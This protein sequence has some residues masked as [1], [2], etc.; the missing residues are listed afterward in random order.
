MRLTRKILIV[1]AT[2]ALVTVIWLW[3]NR[4]EPVDMA[5]YV[6]AD[7]IV[8]IE[9]N[10]LPDILNGIVSTDAYRELAP[11]AGIKSDF[12]KISW[13]SR[14]AALTGIGPSDAVVLSRSQVAVAV[15]GF[16]AAEESSDILKIIPRTALVA[17]TH[18]STW[19]ARAAI[20]KLAGDFARRAYGSPSVERK[21]LDGV[22]FIIWH[23]PVSARRRIVAAVSGSVVVVGNDESAVQAC[24]AVRRGE[25]PSLAANVELQAMRERLDARHS[26]GF[27]FAP[28]GSAARMVEIFAPVFVTQFTDNPQIQS[29]LAVQLPLLTM[30]VLGA[31]GWSARLIDGAIEDRYFLAPSE[32]VAP[33]LS[34]TLIAA[35]SGDSGVSELLPA[36]TYQI[37]RY[38]LRAPAAAWQGFYASLSSQVD[39]AQAHIIERALEALLKPYGIESPRDFLNAAGNEIVTAKIENASE[40]KLLLVVVRD[41]AA[42]RAQVRK[43]LGVNARTKPVGSDELLVSDDPERGAASF[44]GNTLLMGDEED[45]RRCLETHAG[46]SRLKDAE[47]F[48]S[49][50]SGF[51]PAPPFASTMTEDKSA[52][53]SLVNYFVK[54]SGSR[55]G[56]N[57]G[58]SLK[59]ALARRP[60]SVSE[61]RF[62]GEGFFKTT[63]S[64]FG[65][66]GELISRFNAVE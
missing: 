13:L 23:S 64:S 1:M 10:S 12:G 2:L 14:F 25:R 27:G 65:L 3:W 5:A 19:R 60:Y 22:P 36:G 34:S 9:A 40:R 47:D 54:I 6:P 29:A 51:S 53:G 59:D 37:S 55:A 39:V 21:E 50:R 66:F 42:M 63:H 56:A 45:V 46:G 38:T 4:P 48:R 17:E 44:V 41:E 8:Y 26:I 15:L 30:R 52:A 35:D 7:S 43:R 62:D 32:K 18:S 58:V 28:A 24:L 31:G 20:E 57:A 16:E 61:T 33:I 49:A 11:A